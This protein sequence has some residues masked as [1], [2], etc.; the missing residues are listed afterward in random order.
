VQDAIAANPMAAMML[1][2]MTQQFKQQAASGSGE[3]ATNAESL[4]HSAATDTT[5]DGQPSTAAPEA[6]EAGVRQDQQNTLETL[7]GVRG[8][9]KKTTGA[10][11]DAVPGGK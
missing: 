2:G 4:N 3:A 9:I 7:N 5:Q 6:F 10:L 8:Q 11:Q 1:Q